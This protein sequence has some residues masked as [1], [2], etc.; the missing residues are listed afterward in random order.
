MPAAFLP[1][2]FSGF[3]NIRTLAQHVGDYHITRYNYQWV[4]PLP[5]HLCRSHQPIRPSLASDSPLISASVVVLCRYGCGWKDCVKAG[6]PSTRRSNLI[7]HTHSHVSNASY[8][9]ESSKALN[10]EPAIGDDTTLGEVTGVSGPF[11]VAPGMAGTVV[12]AG[13]AGTASQLAFAF[14]NVAAAAAAVAPAVSDPRLILGQKLY[15]A[16]LTHLQNVEDGPVGYVE[17][18][19]TSDAEPT[20]IRLTAALI[21]R[22]IARVPQAK[23]HLLQYESAILNAAVSDPDLKAPLAEVLLHLR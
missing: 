22:N 17:D 1:C 18:P 13:M 2:T 8:V 16:R 9:E 12:P 11:Q 15:A 6:E 7:S 4:P 10:L 23:Y 21:L 20:A 19:S 14:E 3:T 5:S